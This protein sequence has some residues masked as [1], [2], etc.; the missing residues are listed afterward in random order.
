[1]LTGTRDRS[2]RVCSVGS[3][4]FA[5]RQVLSGARMNQLRAFSA[6][7]LSCTAFA[8]FVAC[9]APVDA[10]HHPA[11]NATHADG[12]TIV[13]ANAELGKLVA[14]FEKDGRAVTFHLR[15]GPKMELPPPDPSMSP[16]HEIDGRVTD[17]DGREMTT[18]MGG[19]RFI[20]PTWRME[21]AKGIDPDLRAKDFAIAFE[22]RHAFA[23]WTPPAG[24]EQLRLGALRLARANDPAL[25][26]V[27]GAATGAPTL[28]GGDQPALGTKVVTSANTVNGPVWDVYYYWNYSIW[29]A[30]ISGI[31]PGEHSAVRLNLFNSCKQHIKSWES[32]NHGRC[33]G[34]TSSGMER[35][36]LSGY[37]YDGND[38]RYFYGESDGSDSSK[39]ITGGCLNKYSFTANDGHN[40]HNDTRLQRYA[41]VTGSVGLESR[42]GNYG[43]LCSSFDAHAP[44]SCPTSF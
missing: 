42:Y 20:D 8:L 29:K 27:P 10:E 41:I 21:S 25:D 11:P 18:Q 26:T 30:A 28:E 9:A 2:G 7:A 17:Q 4:N 34:D 19:D 38:T 40:C 13:E 15:Q 14:V 36:C 39:D 37:M 23:Q 43:T 33:A 16:S 22:A 1:M 3:T 32:C 12:L 24:M 35:N 31:T 5:A 44:D 6:L